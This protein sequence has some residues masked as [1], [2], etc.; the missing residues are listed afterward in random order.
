M[1]F[2]CETE[3]ISKISSKFGQVLLKIVASGT[4]IKKC[5]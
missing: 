2:C 3:Q 5:N 4:Y 1:D